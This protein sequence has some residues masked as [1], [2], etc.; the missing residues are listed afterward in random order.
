MSTLPFRSISTF[1]LPLNVHFTSEMEQ[2]LSTI[3]KKNQTRKQL[4]ALAIQANGGFS[5]ATLAAK[6]QGVD[7]GTMLRD[8]ET[9]STVEIFAENPVIQEYA[10]GLA[11]QRILNAGL[12]RLAD[13]T[14]T[15]NFSTNTFRDAID[16]VSKLAGRQ[17]KI[18]EPKRKI[19]YY[20]GNVNITTPFDEHCV[21]TEWGNPAESLLEILSLACCVSMAEVR[22]VMMLT[23]PLSNITLTGF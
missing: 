11:T 9:R 15:P 14:E 12:A 8:P 20:F 4:I 3:L 16:V 10:Q 17:G 1:L 22:A 6:F 7:F 5:I 23:S 21:I 2:R 19:Q 18:N 13:E